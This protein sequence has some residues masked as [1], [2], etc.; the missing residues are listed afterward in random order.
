LEDRDNRKLFLIDNES[1]NLNGTLHH[2]ACHI[3][4]NGQ[5]IVPFPAQTFALNM[6]PARPTSLKP[7]RSPTR[8]RRPSTWVK[9]PDHPLSRMSTLCPS[10]AKRCRSSRSGWARTDALWRGACPVIGFSRFLFVLTR[11]YQMKSVDWQLKSTLFLFAY[12]TRCWVDGMMIG[13]V[14]RP[15]ITPTY[16][17]S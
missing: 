6:F 9:T 13:L 12:N 14:S 11:T 1:F 16:H 5:R 3:C 4:P 15:V 17:G 7:F 10:A 8:S 2:T